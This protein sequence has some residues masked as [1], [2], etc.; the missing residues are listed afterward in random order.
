MY[1]YSGFK[2]ALLPWQPQCLVTFLIVQIPRHLN[3]AVGKF[4]IHMF[5]QKEIVA[6][7]LLFIPIKTMGSR[8]NE[9][10]FKMPN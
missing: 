8:F 10:L 1:K 3:S 9:I 2:T 4:Y 6:P 7:Q 5:N